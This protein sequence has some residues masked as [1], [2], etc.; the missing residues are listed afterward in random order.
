MKPITLYHYTD[1]DRWMKHETRRKNG[2]DTGDL[3]PR[4]LQSLHADV[5]DPR[6]F[7]RA[8][9]ALLHPLPAEWTDNPSFP[10]LWDEFIGTRGDLL[11]EIRVGQDDK[12]V[13]VADAGHI[14]G[15]LY[16]KDDGLNIPDK[17]VNGSPELAF[18]KYQD[19]LVS[20][21]TYVSEGRK[22]SVPEVQIR[23]SISPNELRISP[24]QPI[25]ER[26][27]G[28]NRPLD[29]DDFSPILAIFKHQQLLG[30]WLQQFKTRKPWMRDV[31]AEIKRA[32][33]VREKEGQ[34]FMQT[35]GMR[36][37]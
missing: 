1:F 6:A 30:D 10:G 16:R 9:F 24:S 4:S 11:L 23:R 12:N 29:I 32:N 15:Y 18:A 22:Y 28:E 13:L 25:I 34:Q 31:L 3:E 35:E 33:E 2:I 14:E 17:Y 19:S 8:T 27:I 5:Q 37:V 26:E 20:L 36:K 7:D 21:A